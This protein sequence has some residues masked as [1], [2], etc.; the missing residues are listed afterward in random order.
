VF[1]RKQQM[2]KD[3]NETQQGEIIRGMVT[4]RKCDC[5]GHHEVG[6]TTQKGEY[7]PLKPGMIIEILPVHKNSE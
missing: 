6:V 2:E 1:L 3:N 7:I 5:C 4:A